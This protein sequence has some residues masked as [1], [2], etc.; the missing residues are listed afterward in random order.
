MVF[1]SLGIGWFT[2]A[3]FL[4]GWWQRLDPIQRIQGEI[5]FFGA[6]MVLVAFLW[7]RWTRGGE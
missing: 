2:L 6:A 3:T 1:S 4:R 7:T 5:I